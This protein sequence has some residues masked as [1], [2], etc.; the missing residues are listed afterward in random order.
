MS[1]TQL[2]WGKLFTLLPPKPTFLSSILIF[3]IG[4]AVSGAAPSSAVF[5]FGRAVAGLGAAG[6]MNGAIVLIVRTVPLRKRPVAQGGLGAVFGVASIV[7]PVLGGVF[8]ER[9]S[10]RWCFYVNLPCGAVSAILVLWM[11]RGIAEGGMGASSTGDLGLEGGSANWAAKL[12]A[13][14][15]K[16]DPLGTILFISSIVCLLLA[17]QWGGTTYSWSNWRLILLLVLFPVLLL[18]FVLI[19]IL[20]PETAT[21][22]LRIVTQRSIASSLLFTSTSQASMLVITYFIPLF[23]QALKRYA[24]LSSGL[25]TLPTI[26]SLVVG[27]IIAGGLVQRLGYP[28]P[29]MYISAILASIGGGLISTWKIGVPRSM[30]IGS[31]VLFGLGIGMGMQQPSMTAQIVLEK[32][33]VPTGVALMFFG[34]NLGGAVFVAVAQNLVVDDLAAK[35]GRIAGLEISKSDVVQMGATKIIEAVPEEL[36]TVALQFYRGSVQRAFYLGVGLAAFSVVGALG[37]E[38]RSVKEAETEAET[39]PE[40]GNLNKPGMVKGD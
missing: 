10:W 39:A 1:S 18:A 19:Q 3:E 21:L 8:A 2:L 23:F 32:L 26:L 40:G 30:W 24:P 33:D 22:P 17:L 16:L 9:V 14:L 4:S 37:V 11:L 34:Q 28:A 20:R 12:K 5:I 27:T 13:S 6:M 35:L 31:Q 15:L 38:W 25:A 29:F 36:R 7:G